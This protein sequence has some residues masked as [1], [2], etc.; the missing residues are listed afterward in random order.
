MFVKSPG[1]HFTKPTVDL[2]WTGLANMS[3]LVLPDRSH[4]GNMP[5]TPRYVFE[6][7]LRKILFKIE[8]YH[9]TYNNRKDDA[10]DLFTMK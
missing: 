5:G 6:N 10:S 8:H 1:F 4:L 2:P 3:I 7:L 9:N